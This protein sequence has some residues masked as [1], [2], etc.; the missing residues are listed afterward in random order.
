M[1]NP[2]AVRPASRSRSVRGVSKRSLRLSILVAL[3]VGALWLAAPKAAGQVPFQHQVIDASA[4]GDCKG[5]GDFD[6]D[7]LLDVVQGGARLVLYRWPTWSQIEIAVAQKEFTTDMA[8]SDVDGDGDADLVVPDGDS[9]NNMLWYENPL[10]SGNPL[11][12]SAW[13][14]HV[15]GAKGSWVHD[16]AVGDLDGDGRLDIVTRKGTTTIFS[17][18]APDVWTR[19]ELSAASTQGEGT[20]VG[21]IDGDGDLDLAFNGYWVENAAAGWTKH[22]IA[23]GWST[24]VGVTLADLDADGRTDVL[25]APAESS[26]KLAWYEAL[27]PKSGPW[28]EHVIDG[29]VASIHTFKTGDMDL[30]GD[31]DVVSAQMFGEVVVYRNVGDATSFTAQLVD[32]GGSHNLRLGDLGGDGDLDIVGANFIG[33]ARLEAWLNGTDPSAASVDLGFALAGSF[34]EPSLILPQV[35][36]ANSLEFSVGQALPNAQAVLVLGFTQVNL[37]FH[38]GVFVPDADAFVM[39]QVTAQGTLHVSLDLPAGLPVGFELFAQVWIYDS[40]GPLGL[41]A[42]NGILFTLA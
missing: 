11:S 28:T 33:N 24:Q 16:V 17:Q 41:S 14:R 40:G 13:T 8:V 10:P 18:H 34:G 7:G 29:S 39:L 1:M 23:S 27:Q 22:A 36:S 26:G 42:T 15:V 32:A 9:G 25:L 12:G 19:V 35:T 2:S 6:G 38:G 31:L 4:S 5:I 30:D 37:P 3:A 21:D 20:D